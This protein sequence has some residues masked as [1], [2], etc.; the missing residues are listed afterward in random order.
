MKAGQIVLICCVALALIAFFFFDGAQYLDFELIKS[1]QGELQHWVAQHQLL[2]LL[3]FFGVYV[4]V[5]ALSIPGAA[6]LTLLAGALFGL[7]KGF[8]IV[9]FAS[10]LG[11]TLAFLG[12]R[13]LFKETVQE[14]FGDKLSVINDGIEK[15][16]AFYLFGLRLVPLFP[17]FVINLVMSITS[18]NTRTFYLASQLGMV[19]GTLVYVNAGTQLA[20]LDGVSGILSPGLIASFALLAAFPFIAKRL[21]AVLRKAES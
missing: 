8:V 10:T 17:F 20:Q 1:K 18:I 3:G 5:T 19:A 7:L 21:L 11:A 6:V 15:E 4:C 16:G 9:S 2:A 13:Y 14:K 12:A